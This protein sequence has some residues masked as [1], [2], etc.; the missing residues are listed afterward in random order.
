MTKIKY[1][2]WLGT[3]AEWIKMRP[4]LRLFITN[5]QEFR[6]IA[7][8]QNNLLNNQDYVDDGLPAQT[9]FL[10]KRTIKKTLCGL[11]GWWLVTF[12]SS[13]P[14][15]GK[16]WRAQQ[17]AFLI[18]HGDTVSTLMGAL[19]GK[20]F[21]LTI[22]HIEAG[23]RSF[24]WWSPF[25]EEINRF[26]V[27]RLTSL[28]FAPNAWAVKNLRCLGGIKVNTKQ[29]TLYDSYQSMQF[30]KGKLSLANQVLPAKY[31]VLVCHRQENLAQKNLL[32]NILALIDKEIPA[33]WQCV[34]IVHENT[35]VYLQRQNLL[36]KLQ[37]NQ[38][39]IISSR[40]DYFFMMSLI[41]QSEFILTDGGS[42]Q[43]EC[44]YLGKPCCL[45]RRCSERIEGLGKNVFLSKNC[46]PAIANFMH[47]YQQYRF[48]PLLSEHSP[49]KIIYQKLIN[50]KESFK[51]ED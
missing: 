12:F 5:G 22:V 51:H 9:I 49:S 35:R 7:T 6:L 24:N 8:G 16:I 18:V 20:F 25:P 1:Y 2:F 40:V 30:K 34:F 27:S 14:Q 50:N 3:T 17:D 36:K 15:L 46:L 43:E 28:H 10:S 26:L 42:N 41:N 45:L 31:F 47:H 4:L 11:L 37:Q 44:Y 48:D 23:L 33:V 13:I 39:Y 29:N 21:G 32:A 38:R 19:L